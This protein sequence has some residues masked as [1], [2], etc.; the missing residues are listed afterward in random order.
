MK[1][2]I[3][4]YGHLKNASIKLASIRWVK[5][6]TQL[7]QDTIEAFEDIEPHQKSALRRVWFYANDWEKKCDNLKSKKHER[8][9]K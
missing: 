6:E 2:S 8:N 7:E 3:H 9:E 4:K 5:I 1:I